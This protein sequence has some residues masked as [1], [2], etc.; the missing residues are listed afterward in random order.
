ME[1]GKLNVLIVVIIRIDTFFHK[2]VTQ[3]GELTLAVFS[4]I[5]LIIITGFPLVLKSPEKS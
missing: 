3:V 5:I 2:F 1:L 4:C